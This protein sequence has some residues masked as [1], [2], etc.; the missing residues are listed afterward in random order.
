[1]SFTLSI[2]LTREPLNRLGSSFA[3]ARKIT[4]PIEATLSVEAIV[5]DLNTGNLADLIASCTQDKYDF[6]IEMKACVGSNKEDVFNIGIKGAELDE[7]SFSLS[8]GDRKTVTINF[9]IPIGGPQ[10]ITNGIFFSGS[11]Y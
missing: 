4:F 7:Q 6:N 9:T 1:Q 5:A 2:P 3:Y 11:Q 10:D 8:V